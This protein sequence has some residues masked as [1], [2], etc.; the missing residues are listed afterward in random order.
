MATKSPANR[1]KVEK[2]AAITHTDYT[3]HVK[4]GREWRPVGTVNSF[5]ACEALKASA[6]QQAIAAGYASPEIKTVERVIENGEITSES[7]VS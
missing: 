3:V 7:E 4:L 1:V 6:H 5:A 2:P